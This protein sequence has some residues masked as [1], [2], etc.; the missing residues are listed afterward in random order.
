MLPHSERH[1][2]AGGRAAL[3]KLL[4]FQVWT[5]LPHFKGLWEELISE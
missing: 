2:K 3:G 5:A 1:D 4:V